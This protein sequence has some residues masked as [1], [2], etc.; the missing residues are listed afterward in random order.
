MIE[1]SDD[2]P[3][4][5]SKKLSSVKPKKATTIISSDEGIKFELHDALNADF[6]YIE[7]NRKTSR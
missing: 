3:L 5:P 1:D 7:D 6:L 2:E 4:I